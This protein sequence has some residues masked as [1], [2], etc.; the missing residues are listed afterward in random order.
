MLG[1]IEVMTRATSIG[2]TP[3]ARGVPPSAVVTRAFHEPA[4]RASVKV[5]VIVSAVLSLIV[6]AYPESD[7][8]VSSPV[9][10]SVPRMVRTFPLRT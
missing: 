10:R 6:Q 2:L 1:E 5:Q 8:S 4:I 3:A 7:T 9:G